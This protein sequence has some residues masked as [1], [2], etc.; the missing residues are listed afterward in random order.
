MAVFN[1][2]RN[3][4]IQFIFAIVFIILLLRLIF[5]QLLSDKYEKLATDQAILRKVVYPGRGIIF[6]R[7]GKPI[8]Q[9]VSMYDLMVTPAQVKGTDTFTLCRILG[10]DTAEFK[11]RIITAII[12]NSRNRPS[13]FEPLLTPEK[14][15]KVNENLFRFQPAFF[16]QERPVRSYPF[17]SAAQVLGYV[18]EVDS[19]MLKKSNFFYQMGDYAGRSGLENYYEKILMGQRG[20]QYILRDNFNRPI[21]PYE[22]GAFDTPSVAGRHLHTYIDIEVQELAEKLLSNKVGSVVAIEPQTGGIIAMASSP[23]YDPNELTGPESRKNFNRLFV[24]PALPMLNRGMQGVYPPGSTFKPLGALVALDEGLINPQFGYNCFGRYGPC[25]KPACTHSNAG[26]AANVKLS[27]ANSCNSYYAHVFR[28]ALD[29]PAYRNI[30]LGLMQWKNYMTG[31]G[32]GHRLG[33]DLP[34]EYAGY[35]PDTARYNRVFRK[36]GWNSCTIASLGIGQGEIQATPLQMANTACLIA[37]RGW[38]YIPH[39]VKSIER[40]SAS[41]TILHKFRKKI[42]PLHI[43]DSTYQAVIDGMEMVVTNGTA[44]NAAIEG[45]AV[46]AKTGTVENYFRGKKQQN[47]SFFVAFAPKEKPKIAICVVVENAG[48]GSTWAAP[49]ASLLMEK[50]LTDSIAGD[51]RKAEVERISKVSLIPAR[52]RQELHVRDS[53]NRVK[54]SLQQIKN[55]QLQKRNLSLLKRQ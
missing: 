53:I 51:R 35:I 45:I 31:F 9:N 46:C 7:D 48:F 26:H 33:I 6:D 37:N 52:I 1:Q 5:L 25:G 21:G 13:V 28:M 18:G 27:I 32:L 2:S 14:Y 20:I 36:G 47:H 55:L 34:G 4:T 43:H 11:K 10:I 15:A 38:Y 24:N 8:L 17:K 22:Q 49:I 44:R 29:N 50:F 23:G 39:F 3:I 30:E 19:S 54:D 42:K 16:L 41:D 12:K 40:E